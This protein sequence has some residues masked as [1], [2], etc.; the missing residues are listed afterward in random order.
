MVSKDCSWTRTHCA[1]GKCKLKYR[2]REK[3]PDG[4]WGEFQDWVVGYKNFYEL[5]NDFGPENFEIA[6]HY[7]LCDGMTRDV[8]ENPLYL[9]CQGGQVTGTLG[10]STHPNSHQCGTTQ[11][12]AGSCKLLA[13]G[14]HVCEDGPAQTGTPYPVTFYECSGIVEC[15]VE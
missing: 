2:T 13:D 9:D 1:D 8:P 14:W 7:P 12:C 5:L 4:T 10:P 3:L 15:G 11:V 6:L